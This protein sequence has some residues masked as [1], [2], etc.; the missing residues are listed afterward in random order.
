MPN[1]SKN[2]LIFFCLQHFSFQLL[3]YQPFASL[4]CF[5][6]MQNLVLQPAVFW[7]K[8]KISQDSLLPCWDIESFETVS[9]K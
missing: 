2:F 3:S 9:K 8:R 7:P 4:L 6:L 1:A 5:L